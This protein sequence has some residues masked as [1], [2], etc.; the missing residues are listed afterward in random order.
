MSDS[1]SVSLGCGIAALQ[2][3]SGVDAVISDLPS[4]ETRAQ[5]DK[6]PDLDAF[7]RAIWRALKPDGVAVLM[8]SNLGFAHELTG[9]VDHFRYEIVW[10]K[11]R[12]T[13]FYNSGIRPLK[14]H[15]YLMVFSRVQGTYNPQ[16]TEGHNPI[17]P[18]SRS[19]GHGENYGRGNQ[20][21]KSRAGA[22]DRYPRS[23][24]KTKTVGTTSPIRTHPQQK[25]AE[26]MDWIISTYSNPGDLVVDPFAGSGATLNSAIRLGRLAMGWD[27]CE[28][29]ATKAL[30]D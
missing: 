17:N 15:E 20:V 21:T 8:A 26:L 23:V 27:N 5:F 11:T 7:N 4:G 1:T 28:R 6:R 18:A 25:P 3:L 29:F 22:T 30:Y 13:G 19:N 2:A 9:A 12:A 14:C 24:I 10:E 16:M